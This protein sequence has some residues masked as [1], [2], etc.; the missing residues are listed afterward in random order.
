MVI[1]KYP[2]RL[3]EQTLQVPEGA[4][5]LTAQ[6]QGGRLTLWAKVNPEA[7]IGGRRVDVVGT[8]HPHPHIER[9]AYLASVQ[10]DVFVWHVFVEPAFVGRQP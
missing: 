10:Q 5:A 9:W 8:G 7:E 4:E 2:L 1:W 6:M 3:G